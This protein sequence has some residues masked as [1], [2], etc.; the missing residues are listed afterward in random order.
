MLVT[1]LGAIKLFVNDEEVEFTAIK[2]DLDSRTP[3]VNAR[4]LIQYDY[5]SKMENQELKFCLHSIDVKGDIESGEGFEA[6]S[7]YRNDIKLTIGIEGEFTDFPKYSEDSGNYLSNG[8]RYAPHHS[9]GDRKFNFGV[10]WIQ[11][12]T[13]E[14]D[15]QTWFGADPTLMKPYSY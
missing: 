1:P 14:N 7:F 4:Y 12:L 11:P 6:I 5:E 8:I 3:D 2:M 9:T 10:C 15:I 13:E